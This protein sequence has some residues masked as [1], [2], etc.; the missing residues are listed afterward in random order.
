MKEVTTSSLFAIILPA[1]SLALTFIEVV[2][3]QVY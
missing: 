2:T 3:L 1:I